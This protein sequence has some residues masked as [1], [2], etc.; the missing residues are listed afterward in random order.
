MGLQ[1]AAALEPSHTKLKGHVCEYM[2]HPTPTPNPTQT[3][4]WIHPFLLP[5]PF[6]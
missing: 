4:T 1:I 3:P 5:L 6:S 2:C